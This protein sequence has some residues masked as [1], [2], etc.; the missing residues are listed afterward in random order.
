MSKVYLYKSN[1]KDFLHRGLGVLKDISDTVITE[2]INGIFDMSFYYPLSGILIKEIK[3][4]R[5]VRAKTKKGYQAFRIDAITKSD[6][7]LGVF[8]HAFHITYDLA[9]NFIEDTFIQNKGGESALSQLL[10]KAIIPHDFK[11]TSTIQGPI[12]TRIVRKNLLSVIMGSEDNSLLSRGGGEFERDNFQINWKPSIGKDRGV[13]IKYRKNLVGLNFKSD[14]FNVITQIMPQ[15]YD[16]LLLPEKY[17]KS[18]LIDKYHMPKIAKKEYSDIIS[19]EK[20]KDNKDAI[21]HEIAL[22]KLRQRANQEFIKGIDKPKITCDVEFVDL[23]QTVEY[24][25]YKQLEEV[26]IGDTVTVYHPK[27]DVDVKIKIESYQYDPLS[28]SYINL[29]LGNS[30]NTMLKAFSNADKALSSVEELK[31]NIQESLLEKAIE[32]STALI[33]NGFGGFVK[34][35]PDK[36]L[37]MDADDETTA[38][39]VWRFNKNGIGHSSTGINGPYKFSWTID[40]QFNTEFIGVHSITANKLA[41]DVGQ[42]LDLSSNVSITN[43]VGSI[44]GNKTYID[45]NKEELNN[46]ISKLTQEKDSFTIEFE[47]LRQLLNGDKE[48]LQKIRAIIQSGVDSNGNSYTEWIGN[49]TNSMR[50]SSDG[51]AMVVDGV[52]VVKIKDENVYAKSIFVKNNLGAGNHTIVKYGNIFTIFVWTGGAVW[53]EVEL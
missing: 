33:N 15:G 11:S 36:V 18:P 27:L 25:Q 17:V 19:K 22:D 53:Q 44:E 8:V 42:S 21:D 9:Y 24:E 47:Q 52:D 3:E 41:A 5:I 12:S 34:Y 10:E 30:E 2:Q 48:E 13:K 20:S 4:G 7:F 39:N 40:G 37:I 23:S 1:E 46:S 45:Q 50:M 51:M 43:I 31:N 16:G 6:D 28:D 49:D 32:T 35:Y 14:E 29:T 38:K 26:Y